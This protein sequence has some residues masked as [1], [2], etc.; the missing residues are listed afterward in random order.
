MKELAGISLRKTLMGFFISIQ[1]LVRRIS[2]CWYSDL[3][4]DTDFILMS[5]KVY[6]LKIVSQLYCS[7]KSRP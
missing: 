4:K 5:V 6:L 1:G 3:Q 7:F 2:E